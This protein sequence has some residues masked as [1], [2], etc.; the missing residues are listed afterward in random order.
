MNSCVPIQAITTKNIIEQMNRAH[1][2]GADMIE[3]WLD[4]LLKV[5]NDICKYYNQLNKIFDQK[6]LPI[7]CVLK[8]KFEKG[9]FQGTETDKLKILTKCAELGADFCDFKYNTSQK[10]IDQFNEKKTILNSFFPYTTG[11]KL[12][13]MTHSEHS[14]K[15]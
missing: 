7:L 14:S 9:N 12:R 5:Q 8:D 6:I 11:T 2:E 1:N 15:K 13:H 10:I 4:Q 3:I